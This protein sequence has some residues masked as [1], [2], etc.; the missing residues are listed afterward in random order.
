[1][2]VIEGDGILREQT[3]SLVAGEHYGSTEEMHNDSLHVEELQR[4]HQMQQLR[5]VGSPTESIYFHP[6]EHVGMEH[7]WSK[8]GEN[9]PHME[10]GDIPTSSRA[11]YY[12]MYVQHSGLSNEEIKAMERLMAV[13]YGTPPPYAGHVTSLNRD[14]L[15]EYN[16]RWYH[17]CSS[18]GGSMNQQQVAYENRACNIYGGDQSLHFPHKSWFKWERNKRRL[19]CTF[20]RK[21]R[22]A[23]TLVQ[24]AISI[25]D[26]NVVQNSIVEDTQGLLGFSKLF[27]VAIASFLM[28]FH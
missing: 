23:I 1:M 27:F 16:R 9:Q 3:S 14:I 6:D 2:V 25:M 19:G 4:R 8:G 22:M 20:T 13:I 18:C 5:N 7:D 11:L 15:E 24:I 10:G 26:D 17:I 12:A 21:E 28:L